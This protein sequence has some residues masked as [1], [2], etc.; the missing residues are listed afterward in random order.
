MQG[1]ESHETLQDDRGPWATWVGL[2]GSLGGREAA[3]HPR[4]ARL[5]H[6]LGLAPF[7]CA[8]PLQELIPG[9]RQTSSQAL[10]GEGSSEQ[11][12]QPMGKQGLWSPT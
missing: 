12:V 8:P 9:M 1:I 4:P 7:A 10:T 5:C 11:Q 2:E 3:A 6:P